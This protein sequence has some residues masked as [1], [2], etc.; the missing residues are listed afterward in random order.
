[1]ILF[2]SRDCSKKKAPLSSFRIRPGN[3]EGYGPGAKLPWAQD[4]CLAVK[5]ATRKMKWSSKGSCGKKRAGGQTN[6]DKSSGGNRVERC[7]MESCV[8]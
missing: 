8:R 6:G 3:D 1:M 2:E 7:R 5:E 4:L